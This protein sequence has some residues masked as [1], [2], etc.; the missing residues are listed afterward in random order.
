MGPLNKELFV[1]LGFVTAVEF[2]CIIIFCLYDC[3]LFLGGGGQ[4]GYTV[5]FTKSG[6]QCNLITLI[7]FMTDLSLGIYR[8]SC[9]GHKRN[10]PEEESWNPSLFQF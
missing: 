3:P 8:C 4:M 9:S 7:E 2:L 1:A 6:L 10:A 5:E